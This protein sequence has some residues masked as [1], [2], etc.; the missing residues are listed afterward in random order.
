MDEKRQD[1]NPPQNRIAEKR[2]VFQIDLPK[3]LAGKKIAMKKLSSESDYMEY[4]LCKFL[5]GNF[6]ARE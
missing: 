3:T 4:N 1:K 5:F 2:V 6:R